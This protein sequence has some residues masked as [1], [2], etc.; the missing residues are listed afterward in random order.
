MVDP[1]AGLVPV[2]ILYGPGFGYIIPS[3]RMKILRFP[4]PS[5]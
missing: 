4:E 5:Y 1:V 3:G 2:K